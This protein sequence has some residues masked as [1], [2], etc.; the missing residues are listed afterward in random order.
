MPVKGKKMKDNCKQPSIPALCLFQ[1]QR[2]N[3]PEH[4]QHD[5]LFTQSLPHTEISTHLPVHLML[6]I[7][8]KSARPETWG[9]MKM[10]TLEYTSSYTGFSSNT[11]TRHVAY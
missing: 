10:S 4:V 1:R 9:P 6:A 8:T 11:T 2:L 7:G 3:S 5:I